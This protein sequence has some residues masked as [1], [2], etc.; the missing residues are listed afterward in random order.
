MSLFTIG[1]DQIRDQVSQAFGDTDHYLVALK[2][3]S[4]A[5]GILKLLLSNFIYT[6][7]ASRE[8]ILHFSTEGIHIKEVGLYDHAPFR[9]VPWQDIRSVDAQ[10]TD[11]KTILTIH[12]ADKAESFEVGLG[13]GIMEGNE[14]RLGRLIKQNWLRPAPVTN[15]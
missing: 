3:N 7:S 13:G 2:H 6:A 14:G 15:S 4:I 11:S 10:A 8:F 12:H 9:F 1:T 5:G